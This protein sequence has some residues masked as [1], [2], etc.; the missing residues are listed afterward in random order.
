MRL[1]L[2]QLL[3]LLEILA[4]VGLIAFTTYLTVFLVKDAGVREAMYGWGVFLLNIGFVTTMLTIP[5]HEIV[6]S[7]PISFMSFIV[8]TF[9]MI[10]GLMI[11]WGLF[12]FSHQPRSN[13]LLFLATFMGGAL[14]TFTIVRSLEGEVFLVALVTGDINKI[15]WRTQ[16]FGI[17]LVMLSI[18][19]LF[20][21]INDIKNRIEIGRRYPR[22]QRHIQALGISEI[23]ITACI[24]IGGLALAMKNSFSF[25][26]F[27]LSVIAIIGSVLSAQ[28]VLQKRMYL[29][30]PIYLELINAIDG[31]NASIGW[32]FYV[33]G[34]LGPEPLVYKFNNLSLLDPKTKKE[35]IYEFGIKLLSTPSFQG[36]YDQSTIR[37]TLK[38][39]FSAEILFITTFVT[40]TSK[41][42]YDARFE[43]KPYAGFLLLIR[44]RKF[45]WLLDHVSTW[46]E[47]I[48]DLVTNRTLEDLS[49]DVVDV[50]VKAAI[51]DIVSGKAFLYHG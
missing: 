42:Q 50:G 8:L 45:R 4:G 9:D 25:P 34:Q 17:T 38:A 26:L 22:E 15:T 49:K 23:T 1:N 32:G 33:F 27:F 47:F 3:A 48:N 29:L 18:L 51:Y 19:V 10:G 28:L 44:E 12:Y 35:I 21:V 20:L 40:T 6:P 11:L 37:L 39:P 7:I 36:E 14:W 24:G 13:L 30:F 2:S 43:Q 31:E 46:Q 41:D 5:L 16:L